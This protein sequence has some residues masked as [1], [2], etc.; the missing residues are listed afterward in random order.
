MRRIMSQRSPPLSR[1]NY[2]PF[3]LQ[4]DQKLD[5]P[6]VYPRNECIR[7]EISICL[8]SQGAP[9]RMDTNPN[10]HLYGRGQSINP[11]VSTRRDHRACQ[12]SRRFSTRSL[13]L[14]TISSMLNE[15]IV[16][17]DN[18]VDFRRD[19][20]ACRQS[21]RSRC[22]SKKLTGPGITLLNPK[23]ST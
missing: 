6:S 3:V 19:R 15:I 20:C 1:P 8:D 21:R 18:F 10:I 16:P 11:F 14:S 7:M 13:C 2:E 22:K 17:V 12:Q 5:H 23:P 4:L 9:R